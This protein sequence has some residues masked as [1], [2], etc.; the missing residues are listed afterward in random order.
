VARKN[1]KKTLLAV[2]ADKL[3]GCRD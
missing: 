2:S 1:R 3:P